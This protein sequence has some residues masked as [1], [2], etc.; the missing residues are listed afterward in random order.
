MIAVFLYFTI[1]SLFNKVYTMAQKRIQKELADLQKNL[2]TNCS[3]G[4]IDSV[5]D[6][7]YWQA[8]IYGPDDS[9]YAGGVFFLKIHFPSDYPFR[10]PKVSFITKIYHPNMIANRDIGLGIFYSWSPV[11]TISKVLL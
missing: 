9:P 8:T 11:F 10:P 4:P 6:P 3:A 7:F 1:Y 5:N 2:P